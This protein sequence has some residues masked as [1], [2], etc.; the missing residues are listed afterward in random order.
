MMQKAI[1]VASILFFFLCPVLAQAQ[2]APTTCPTNYTCSYQSSS[3]HALLG[4]AQDGQPESRVGFLTFDGSGNLSGVLSGN[5]NG[6]VVA[7]QAVSGTCVSG[8]A[9]S[10][11]TLNFNNSLGGNPASLAFVTAPDGTHTDL[12]IAGSMLAS[13]TRVVV[14][15]CRGN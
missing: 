12:I 1:L 8:S 4:N 13:D 3:T 11:A 9:T 6:T 10:L 15:V 5:L 7:N 14:A 2:G